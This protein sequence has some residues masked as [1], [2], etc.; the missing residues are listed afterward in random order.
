MKQHFTS[1]MSLALVFVTVSHAAENPDHKLSEW[2]LG[3]VLFGEEVDKDA[4]TGK[5]VVIEH[6]GV[7]CPP[8]IA[9]LPHLAKLDKRHREDG[10]LII[11][12]ESQGHAKAQ[13]EPL[14]KKNR[15]E[16]TITS[17]AS[18]PIKFSG[19][20]H[21]FIFDVEGKLLFNGHPGHDDFER[22]LKRA[23]KDVGE[24]IEEDETVAG[25]LFES[26]SWANT[27]GVE[28]RAAVKTATVTSVTF[29]LPDGKVVNYPMNKLSKSSQ[30]LITEA[31]AEQE[32][33]EKPSSD[34]N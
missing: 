8:C 11:G 6:W 31:L 26:Q 19:I 27:E 25:N 20:P 7:N 34:S 12:A 4:L 9:L 30:K 13:I 14:V 29:L 28:I 17:G 18:G 22:T 33:N 32:E 15:I 10:L 3:K 2:K 21:A 24:Q 16:Y 23:L 1:W 5:V